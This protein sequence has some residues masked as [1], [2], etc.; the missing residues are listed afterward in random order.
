MSSPSPMVYHPQ[1]TNTFT[2]IVA[3]YPTVFQPD[4]H[5]QTVEHSITHHI[6]TTGPQISAR[7]R[8]LAPE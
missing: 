5:N 3:E 6:Q 7:A 2:A 8:R 1:L 4:F